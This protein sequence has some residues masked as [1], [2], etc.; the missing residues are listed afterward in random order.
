MDTIHKKIKDFRKSNGWTQ[1]YIAQII[2]ITQSAY[3]QFENGE[4]KSM[5]VI[6]LMKY[7]EAF[8]LSANWLLGLEREA[9][10][11]ETSQLYAKTR[12]E[13]YRAS[14]VI[15]GGNMTEEQRAALLQQ[16]QNLMNELK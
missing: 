2:G 1:E 8:N 15:E 12:N 16:L 6:T 7:C 14:K 4:T 11:A 5:K 9:E 10:I 13:I 3:S